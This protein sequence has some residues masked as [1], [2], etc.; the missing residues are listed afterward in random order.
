[1]GQRYWTGTRRI[2][3]SSSVVSVLTYVRLAWGLTD[4]SYDGTMG[5]PDRS[6]DRLV[7][8]A[9]LEIKTESENTVVNSSSINRII[10][11]VHF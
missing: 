9:D 4:V 11:K 6:N 10:M 1:M 3:R 5:D 7:M 8:L 2:L